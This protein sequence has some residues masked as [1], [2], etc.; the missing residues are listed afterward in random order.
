[1]AATNHAQGLNTDGWPPDIEAVIED[2][3]AGLTIEAIAQ[4]HNKSTK[5]ISRRLQLPG[6][7]AEIAQRQLDRFASTR[8]R[9][10]T[11]SDRAAEVLA[12]LLDSEDER[13]RLQAA[14][15]LLVTA[16]RWHHQLYAEHQVEDRLQALERRDRNQQD[17]DAQ[18][19]RVTRST[20]KNQEN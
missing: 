7:C 17:I 12:G 4:R 20:A 9:L 2:R 18:A 10:V 3:A 19:Q 1:M 11:D 6:V 5:T 16:S 14:V 15:Q 8:A 13:L